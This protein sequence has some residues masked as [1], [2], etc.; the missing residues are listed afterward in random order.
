MAEVAQVANG[1]NGGTG[2]TGGNGHAG[3][4]QNLFVNGTALSAIYHQL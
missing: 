2:G 4:T 3:Q 1:G